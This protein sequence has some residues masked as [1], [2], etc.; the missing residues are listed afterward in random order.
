ML[1]VNAEVCLEWSLLILYQLGTILNIKTLPCSA[2][3]RYH[4]PALEGQDGTQPIII[5]IMNIY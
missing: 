3:I 2:G 1:V 4:S 5:I